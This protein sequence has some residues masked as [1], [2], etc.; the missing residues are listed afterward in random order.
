MVRRNIPAS[1]LIVVHVVSNTDGACS[2][3][4]VFSVQPMRVWYSACPG[5]NTLF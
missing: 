2:H 4:H 3:L 5:S 1:D